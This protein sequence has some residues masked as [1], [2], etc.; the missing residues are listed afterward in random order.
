MID[1][2]T[3]TVDVVTPG[4]DIVKT[5]PTQAREGDHVTYD[6]AVKNTG[7]VPLSN[8]TVTDTVLGTI[9]T[10]ASLPA[11]A[12]V[13]LHKQYT[14]PFARTADVVNVASACVIATPAIGNVGFCDSASHTLDVIHPA[15][16]VVKTVDKPVITAGKTVVYS[17][18][19]TNPGDI[20][21]SGVK[22]TDNKCGPSSGLT[23]TGGDTDSDNLLDPGEIWA[24]TCS[25]VISVD[26]DQHRHG[27]GHGPGGA[28][29][30]R[31]RH[32]HRGRR[33]PWPHR[34]QDRPPAGPRG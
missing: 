28:E 18:S 7:D 11:G 17:Y 31:H 19:V 20:A 2:A 1:T 5:G 23:R 16:Q 25:A 14:I 26:T 12:T 8:V 13:T 32:H 10:V 15:I 4:L 29:G 34:R 27:R 9:G 21:L 22:V 33:P 30:H 6:F 3:A 24:F